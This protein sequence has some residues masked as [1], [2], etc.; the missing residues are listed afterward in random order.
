MTIVADPSEV[1]PKIRQHLL[2]SGILALSFVAAVKTG[3]KP[4]ATIPIL[5]MVVHRGG[6]VFCSTHRT[7]GIFRQYLASDIDSVRVTEG[8]GV[9]PS[10]LDV[11]ETDPAKNEFAVPLSNTIDVRELR[12]LLVAQ[13]YRVL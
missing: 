8:S 1:P 12:A 9:R 4:N 13:N 2:E 10:R 6:L 5:W 7:R 3:Y 11:I